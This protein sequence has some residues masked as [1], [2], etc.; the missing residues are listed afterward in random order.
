[1]AELREGQSF[2]DLLWEQAKAH[3]EMYIAGMRAADGESAR[4]L[5]R[6]IA[7]VEETLTFLRPVENGFSLNAHCARAKLREALAEAQR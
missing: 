1:M 4:K 5:A 2:A 3:Q 6:L 7:A